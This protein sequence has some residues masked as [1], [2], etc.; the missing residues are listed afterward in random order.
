MAQSTAEVVAPLNTL[1]MSDLK[2]GRAKI[3][4]WLRAKTNDN[5]TI[6]RIETVARNIPVLGSVFAA[7]DV[8]SDVM[9]IYDKGVNNAEFTDWV[10]LGI[11][12]IAIIPAP[13]TAT[14][15]SVARPALFLIKEE[16]KKSH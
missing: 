7:V 15:R 5:I 11:D 4:K 16:T 14:V 10:N 9:D 3:D 8:V 1:A 13:A 12:A 6:D 2:A